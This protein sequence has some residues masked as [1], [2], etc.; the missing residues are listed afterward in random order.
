MILKVR[1][2]QSG[3]KF[4]DN[5]T[6]LEYSFIEDLNPKEMFNYKILDS[7]SNKRKIHVHGNNKDTGKVINIAINL[8]C[9]I[10]ND[11]GKT[12]EKLN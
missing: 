2:F 11:E 10:L 8:E 4:F 5:L 6:H 7:N 9:Y 1:N 12:I 3:W